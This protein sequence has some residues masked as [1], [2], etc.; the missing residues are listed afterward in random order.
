MVVVGVGNTLKA[1]DAAG[2]LVAEMLRGTCPNRV[3]DAGQA[4]ENFTGPIRRAC[5]ETVVVVD[6]ADFGGEPGEVR[7]AHAEGVAGELIGTHGAPLSVFMRFVAEETGAMVVLVAVQV[8]STALGETMCPE[9][10]EAVRRIAL[11]LDALL[12]G[13]EIDD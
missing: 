9:V 2:P 7:I 4:P 1:D 3:F 12:G 6:A 10:S 13:R 5:P 11:E 8:R